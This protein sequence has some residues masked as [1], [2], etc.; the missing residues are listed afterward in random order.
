[1]VP[2]SASYLTQ[3]PPTDGD[4]VDRSAQLFPPT[5]RVVYRMAPLIQ[6]ICQLRFPTLLAI[7]SKP[8]VDFQEMIRDH[9]PLLQRNVEPI[10][11][12]LIPE[13]LQVL[14]AQVSSLTYLFST[15]DRTSTVTLSANS[16][17]L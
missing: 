16:I 4:M 13:Q 5:P 12:E 9:F 15:E 7:E 17:A 14:F 8:P 6:V 11:G 3:R 10:P 1:M 2:P